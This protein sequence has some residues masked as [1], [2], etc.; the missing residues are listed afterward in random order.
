[1]KYIEIYWVIEDFFFTLGRL[2][3][4]VLPSLAMDEADSPIPFH[5]RLEE[6]SN[7]IFGNPKYFIN[8]LFTL[9]NSPFD[10]KYSHQGL[11]VPNQLEAPAWI[12]IIEK[13]T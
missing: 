4:W 7:G 1:M 9:S 13:G 10:S 11:R 3:L 2:G 6:P 5:T 8:F 12:I